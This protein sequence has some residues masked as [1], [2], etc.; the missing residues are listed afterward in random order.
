MVETAVQST[1]DVAAIDELS[2][3]HQRLRTEMA[4][5]IHGQ[6]HSLLMGVLGRK[7]GRLS[8]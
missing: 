6:G 1:D 5:V 4:K 3:D 2:Q 8:R 7:M